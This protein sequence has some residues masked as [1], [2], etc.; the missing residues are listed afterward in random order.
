MDFSEELVEYLKSKESLYKNQT[1]IKL[2]FYEILLI[3]DKSEEAYLKLREMMVINKDELSHNQRLSLHSIL[4]EFCRYKHVKGN[5]SYLRERFGLFK[6]AMEQKLYA[7]EGDIYMDDK[8]FEIIVGVAI[9]LEEYEW[10]GQFIEKYKDMLS[11]KNA[12]AVIKSSGARL[13]SAKGEHRE[14]LNLLNSIG[15]IR[16]VQYKLVVKSLILIVY[17]ELEMFDQAMYFLDAYRHFINNN[18][19]SFME[20]DNLRNENFRKYMYRLLKLRSNSN[21]QETAELLE[22]LKKNQNIN[23]RKWLQE[24]ALE[25]AKKENFAII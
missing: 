2:H 16:D 7:I 5:E 21:K 17:F 3:K 1:H 15:V 25:I 20:I 19:K 14:A 10:A 8:F 9:S 4:Q 13:L 24:K 6:K 23:H 11:P 18:K 22:D 12:D